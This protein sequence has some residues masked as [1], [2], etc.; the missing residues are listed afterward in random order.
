MTTDEEVLDVLVE[1]ED[2]A[3]AEAQADVELDLARVAQSVVR[4]FLIRQPYLRKDEHDLLSDAQLGAVRAQLTYDPEKG[5]SVL[6]YTFAMARY[7]V[8]D[9]IRDRS[10]VPRTAYQKG[11]RLEDLPAHR[12]P[13]TELVDEEGR[14]RLVVD[15]NAT[16]A[17]Q[18]VE[19]RLALLSLLQTLSEKEQMILV[20][21]YFEDMAWQDIAD[22]YGVTPSRISQIAHKAYDKLRRHL[23]T[24]EFREWQ[25]Q[26]H[27]AQRT[28]MSFVV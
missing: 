24:D 7:A 16:G 28:R 1:D 23:V 17:F 4:Q 9:G 12:Q 22:L 20:L 11:V 8:L 27:E 25:E 15:S 19:D 2:L 26:Q 21:H 6:G 3:L 13:P 14:D 18:V 10:P 5:H